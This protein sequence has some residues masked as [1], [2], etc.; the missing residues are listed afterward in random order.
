MEKVL[1]LLWLGIAIDLVGFFAT[2]AAR[3]RNVKEGRVP[4]RRKH[5]R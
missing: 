4:C 1:V 3:G 2:I 5:E